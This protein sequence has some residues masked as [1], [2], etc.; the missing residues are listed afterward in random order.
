ML[1]DCWHAQPQTKCDPWHADML[2]LTL[3]LMEC[4]QLEQ[5]LAQQQ[6]MQAHILMTQQEQAVM[7]KHINDM[8]A[9]QQA[10]VKGA[11]ELMQERDRM[12]QFLGMLPLLSCKA[13]MPNHVDVRWAQGSDDVAQCMQSRPLPSAPEKGCKGRPHACSSNWK[14]SLAAAEPLCMRVCAWN[15]R[16]PQ[17]CGCLHI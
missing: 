12:L 7:H 10:A 14:V 11:Q 2:T 1:A 4:M 15:A 16:C 9:W 17:C 8:Y 6:S 3:T 13:G 5:A